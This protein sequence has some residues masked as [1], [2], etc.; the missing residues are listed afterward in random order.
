MEVTQSV[1]LL[2][3]SELWDFLVNTPMNYSNLTTEQRAALDS[4]K[5]SYCETAKID[6]L[7]DADYESRV[8]TGIIEA[9]AKRLF[10]L[11]VERLAKGAESLSY[12][13]RVALIEHV[14]SQI[15]P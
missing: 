9:E 12:E 7:T 3:A 10:G 14:E 13:A 6:S 8:M 15:A 4:L 11:A 5:A 1:K 2:V